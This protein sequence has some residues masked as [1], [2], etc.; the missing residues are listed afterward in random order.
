M[1]ARGIPKAGVS[2]THTSYLRWGTP[3]QEYPPYWSDGGGGLS[4]VGYPPNTVHPGPGLTGCTQGEYTLT[5]SASGYLRWGTSW[6]QYHPPRLDLAGVS[7]LNG[8]GWGIEFSPH[9]SQVWTGM[10]KSNCNLPSGITYTVGSKDLFSH[11]EMN[12]SLATL[13]LFVN[14]LVI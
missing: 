14:S 10:T 7:P 11:W 8:P 5:R 13:L 6:H 12:S 1:N 4:K 2:S 9:H 3:G